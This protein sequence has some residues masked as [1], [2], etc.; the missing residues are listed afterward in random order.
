MPRAPPFGGAVERSETERVTPGRNRFRHGPWP[1]QLPRRGR[2]W[3]RRKVYSLTADFFLSLNSEDEACRFCQGLALSGKT[4]PGRGKMSPPGDKKGERC[5]AQ[6][7]ERD[8]RSNQ[9]SPSRLRRA[10]SPERERLWQGRKV[11]S[12]TAGFFLSLNSEDETCRFCQRLPLSGELSSAARLRGFVSGEPPSVT[13]PG[14]ASFPE[15]DALGKGV[16]SMLYRST[17]SGS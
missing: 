2:P 15:G 10:T 6:A 14:R 13:A 8:L 17:C 7:T 4:S 3:Q 11:Y 9:P 12:L 16:K 5:R 1:C